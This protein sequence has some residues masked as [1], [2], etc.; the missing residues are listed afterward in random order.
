MPVQAASQD[1]AQEVSQVEVG[2][3]S[4]LRRVLVEDS[5]VWAAVVEV[6]LLPPTH[7]KSSSKYFL[8]SL[9]IYTLP[10]ALEEH[11]Y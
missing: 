11:V 2:R 9:Q 4:H 6:D 8:L 3:R 5:V 10:K 7:R 1:S